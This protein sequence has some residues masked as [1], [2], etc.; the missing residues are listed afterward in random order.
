MTI[1]RGNGTPDQAGPV[2][3][4]VTDGDRGDIV[5][6]DDGLSWNIDSNVLS[7]AGRALIDDVDNITQ[8][9]TLE[10]AKSGD[11]SDITSLSGIT[12]GISTVD[13]IDFDVNATPA[14]AVGR[15]KWKNNEGGPEIGMRGG[16]VTLQLGQE[17]VVYIYNNT[18]SPLSDGQVV[19]VNGSQGQRLT[20]AL[21]KADSDATS[22][23]IVGV[24]TEPIANNSSGFIT[25]MGMVNG[26]NTSGYSDGDLLWLSPTTAGAFTKT[27][28]VAPQHLVMVGYVVKGGSVGAGSI[29]I[30]VQNGYELEELHN[31]LIT[32]AANNDSLFYDNATAVWK[33]LTPTNARTA[34]GLGTIAT[35]AASSVAITGGAIDGTVIGGTIPASVKGSSVISTTTIQDGFTTLANGSTAMGFGS[36]GM[37]RVTPTATTSYTT[38]VPPAGTRCTLFILTSG[39]SSYTITFSTGFRTATATLATGTVTAKYFIINYV[40]DGTSLLEISRTA[41]L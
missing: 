17:M 15:I 27:K 3:V 7:G 31:V 40:S 24:V 39:T 16:N 10:A 9:A 30:H 6:T 21:A 37:V 33:N 29:Y 12:G 32:S 22:A 23:A 34:L 2:I 14:D 1:Y 36:F 11:N 38:T 4:T 26:V 35:Q 25:A 8:R 28:P 20:V 41:A 13:Y 19:Y 18:G 5:V